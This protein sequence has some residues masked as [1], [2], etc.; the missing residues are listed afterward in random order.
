MAESIAPEFARFIADER[1]A[2]R[3]TIFPKPTGEGQ[4]FQ[5]VNVDARR[6]TALLRVAARRASGLFRPSKHAEVVWTEAGSE[7]AVGFDKMSV[8]LAQG[9]IELLIPV[10]CDQ[11]RAAQ[12]T[13]RFAVGSPGAPAGLYAAS[14]RVPEGPELIVNAWGEALVAFGWHCLLELITGIAGATGK[15]KRGNVLVPV[16]LSVTSRG[17]EIVPM[18]RHRFAGSSSLKQAP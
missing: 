6:A 3:L 8:K 13:V 11:L 17:I 18:T 12:V 5:G 7:L 9:L 4:V 16:E 2:Q 15:D 10:R 1:S 14:S